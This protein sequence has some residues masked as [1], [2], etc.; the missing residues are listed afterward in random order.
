[1]THRNHSLFPSDPFGVP[2]NLLE[3]CLFDAPF[4]S[5]NSPLPRHFERLTPSS[6][7]GEGFFP[8][9]FPTCTLIGVFGSFQPLLNYY[10][11][12]GLC[13]QPVR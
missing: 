8:Q 4:H 5:K 2:A 6:V 1:M 7:Y 12:G 10:D 13:P 9:T 11:S 3:A